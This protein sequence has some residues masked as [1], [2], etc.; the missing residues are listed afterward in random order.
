MTHIARLFG[1]ALG[2]ATLVVMLAACG[3]GDGAADASTGGTSG[4]TGGSGSGGGST[5]TIEG[6]ATPSS[7]SVVTATNAN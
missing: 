3:S 7:V 5:A 2:L 4:G 1:G 6:V